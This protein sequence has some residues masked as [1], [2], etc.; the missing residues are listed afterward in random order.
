MPAPKQ[1][2]KRRPQRP[3]ANAPSI[4]ANIVFGPVR[5]PD[6]GVL[7]VFCCEGLSFSATA[8]KLLNP[9][10]NV[11]ERAASA[12][13]F[14]GKSNSA[15]E[16]VAPEGTGLSRLIVVGIGKEDAKPRDFVKLGGASFGRLASAARELTIVADVPGEALT[17]Q[18]AADL[19]LGITLRA[20][21]FERYKTKRKEGE[22]KREDVRVTIA[23]AEHA[24]ARKSWAERESVGA[25]VALARDLVNEPPNILYPEEF[26]RRVADLKQ[27]G[28]TVEV[29]EQTAMK[30]LGMNA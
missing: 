29:L 2:P 12:D 20:Y 3:Q 10:Q 1:R 25:G 4:S 21:S 8:K 14:T 11:L 24:A 6:R 15:L 19:A 16:L 5:I 23:L 18:D 22:E 30:K 26:A 17:P 27:V 7:L 13:R 9:L 28:V